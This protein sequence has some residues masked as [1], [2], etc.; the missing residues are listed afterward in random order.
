MDANLPPGVDLGANRGPAIIRST[1]AVAALATVIVIARLISK[2]IQKAK[3]NLS[4]YT[5]VL[6]LIGCWGLTGIVIRSKK[7]DS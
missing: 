4:D 3:W 6:G 1:A 2:K 5:V 7:P